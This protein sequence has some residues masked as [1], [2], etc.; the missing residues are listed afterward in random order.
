[1]ENHI[2]M[3]KEYTKGLVYNISLYTDSNI[4]NTISQF[5][6]CFVLSTNFRSREEPRAFLVVTKNSWYSREQR[7]C[8]NEAKP[9][10]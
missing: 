1:M 3:R 9:S 6:F 2:D 10:F 4:P 5:L 7:R 8:F